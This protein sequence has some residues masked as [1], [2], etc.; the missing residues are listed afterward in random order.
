M[1]KL[2]YHLWLVQVEIFHDV[3]ELLFALGQSRIVQSLFSNGSHCVA[4][5]IVR[6]V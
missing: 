1:V 6:W 4:V 5:I 2:T 3:D